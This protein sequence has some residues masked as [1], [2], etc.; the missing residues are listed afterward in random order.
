MKK[1]TQEKIR[2]DSQYNEELRSL[3]KFDRHELKECKVCDRIVD[4]V[5]ICKRCEIIERDRAIRDSRVN[6]V[7]I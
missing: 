5:D 1:E 3:V 6:G 4:E 2:Q 7:L